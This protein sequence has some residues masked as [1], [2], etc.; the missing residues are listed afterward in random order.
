LIKTCRD[1]GCDFELSEKEAEWYSERGLDEPERCKECRDARRNISDQWIECKLCGAEF[2]WSADAQRAA[3]TYQGPG[4]YDP[5]GYCS[6]CR[7]ELD[8]FSEETLICS[9][10]HTAFSFTP[11]QQVVYRRKD[12]TEPS[13]CPDCRQKAREGEPLRVEIYNARGEIVGYAYRRGNRTDRYDLAMNPI[14]HTYHHGGRS[15]HFEASGQKKGTT[16]H[17]GNQSEY[18][19]LKGE[20]VWRSYHY[21]GYS[22]H[23]GVNG[24]FMGRSRY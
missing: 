22:E 16:F 15:E 9:W 14:G 13:R 20:L 3:R 5:P 21:K 8:N 1:C 18:R 10:C 7:N 24:E 12:W 4:G 2:C 6:G 23:Y 11:Y 17:N 19:N